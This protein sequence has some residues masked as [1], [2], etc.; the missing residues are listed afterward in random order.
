M[1]WPS[2]WRISRRQTRVLAEDVAGPTACPV[3]TCSHANF[4]LTNVLPERRVPLFDVAPGSLDPTFVQDVV[5][6]SDPGLETPFLQVV[7]DWYDSLP[8]ALLEILRG[9]PF[10]ELGFILRDS[11]D[12][13]ALGKSSS[14][15]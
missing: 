12:W 6:E 11:E 9:C 3:S 4:S 5:A 15:D 2:G 14:F 1:Y 10:L 7:V 8:I 13:L